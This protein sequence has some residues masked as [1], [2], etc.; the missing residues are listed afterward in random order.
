M[1]YPLVRLYWDP[2]MDLSLCCRYNFCLF[3]KEAGTSCQSSTCCWAARLCLLPAQPHTEPGLLLLQLR[4][5]KAVL[6][7]SGR[8]EIAPPVEFAIS[9]HILFHIPWEVLSWSSAMGSVLSPAE[10]AWGTQ[11]GKSVCGDRGSSKIRSAGMGD[12]RFMRDVKEGKK[13]THSQP[14]QTSPALFPFHTFFF[15]SLPKLCWHI[16][17]LC[18]CTELLIPLKQIDKQIQTSLIL[19][20]LPQSFLPLVVSL[21]G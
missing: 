9:S 20:G 5:H 14:T 6:C 11:A 18:C 19:F 10:V 21:E 8:G 1:K 13:C 12:Q 17:A 7:V 4:E 3:S 16:S 2:M 15:T